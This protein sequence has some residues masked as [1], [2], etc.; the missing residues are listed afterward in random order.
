MEQS[1]LCQFPTK[2]EIM[3][4]E[5]KQPIVYV[6]CFTQLHIKGEI[7]IKVLLSVTA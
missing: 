1:V 3:Q 2:P 6:L 7:S 5:G 4:D